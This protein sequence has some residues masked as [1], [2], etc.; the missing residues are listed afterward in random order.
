MVKIDHFR[1]I[2]NKFRWGCLWYINSLFRKA[3]NKS[4]VWECTIRRRP[5]SYCC[6]WF[7]LFLSQL[8]TSVICKFTTLNV[9]RFLLSIFNLR[10]FAERVLSFFID[11]QPKPIT[12]SVAK[13][14]DFYT[15]KST[16]KILHLLGGGLFFHLLFVFCSFLFFQAI[17][18]E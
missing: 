17:I 16:K 2:P 4:W 1:S 9:R 18:S 10:S 13:M 14:Q 3:V 15:E 8:G 12:L 5:K 7:L 6:C 11:L